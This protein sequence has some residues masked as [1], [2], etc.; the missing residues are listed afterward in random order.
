MD[1]NQVD[2]IV[3]VFKN[4]DSAQLVIKDLRENYKPM[5]VSIKDPTAIRKDE[6]G[7]LHIQ[8]TADTS[9]G[10]GAA[11]GGAIGGVLGLLAGPGAVI[12]G[13]AGAALAGGLVA[14]FHDVGF[15]NDRLKELAS[16]LE[17]G[18]SLF[19]AAVQNS[20]IPGLEKILVAADGKVIT[21][22][23]DQQLIDQ[24]ERDILEEYQ[25]SD[26]LVIQDKVNQAKRGFSQQED[27]DIK[28][29]GV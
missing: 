13:A 16:T 19:I 23:F 10:R 15:K 2:I 7:H 17:P 11:I 8:E 24:L 27:L 22:S 28:K 4:G 25:K 18:S 3:A 21:S 9:G 6:N 14:K 26:H 12:L 1:S 29:S 20:V 5:L